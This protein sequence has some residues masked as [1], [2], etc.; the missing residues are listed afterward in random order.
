MIS[1]GR[2]DNNWSKKIA[3]I[4]QDEYSKNHKKTGHGW[5]LRTRVRAFMLDFKFIS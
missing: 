4:F 2:I 3:K 1:K 5:R